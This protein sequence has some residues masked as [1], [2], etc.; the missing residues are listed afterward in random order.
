MYELLGICLS[1]A[2]LLAI[3]SFGSL[4]AAAFWRGASKASGWVSASTRARFLFLLRVTPGLA[5]ILG[6]AALLVPSYLA[7]EPRDTGEIVSLELGLL[8]ALSLY[9]VGLALWRAVAARLATRRLVE[10]WLKH[11]EPLHIQDVT[12]PA[13]RI[14]HPFPVLAIVGAVRPRL[15]VAEQILRSLSEEEIAAAVAHENGHLVAGDNVKRGLLRAC[16]DMLAFIP[17]GSSLDRS[18]TKAAEAA[19]DEYAARGGASMSL[20]LASALLKVARLAPGGARPARVA[21]ASLIAED[22]G[23]IT[24]RVLRLTQ[25]AAVPGCPRRAQAAGWSLAVCICL[26]VVLMAAILTY[27]VANPLTVIHEGLEYFVAA[28]Q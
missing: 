28:L 12:I 2:G 5:A 10:D 24:S 11:A 21:G 3:N 25:L 8:A 20:N 17:F 26:S 1:L 9:G 4:L 14:Q 19:A 13:F 27:S 15:F 22:L 18:W 23:N 16:R 7:N 6:V